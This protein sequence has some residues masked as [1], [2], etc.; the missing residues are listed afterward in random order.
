MARPDASWRI[1]T[2]QEAPRRARTCCQPGLVLDHPGSSWIC[3]DQLGS[4]WIILDQP[5][6]VLDHPGSLSTSL[7]VIHNLGLRLP[8]NFHNIVARPGGTWHVLATPKARPGCPGAS[9]RDLLRPK[10]DIL[11]NEH[12]ARDLGPLQSF[13]NGFSGTPRCNQMKHNN[14]F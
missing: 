6:L 9:W 11:S 4:S 5:G 7:D 3:L 12:H 2:R 1:L 10:T 13:A 8:A 14:S